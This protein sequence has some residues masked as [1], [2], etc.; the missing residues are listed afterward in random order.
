MDYAKGVMTFSLTL[1]GS[2]KTFA[3]LLLEDDEKN[4]AV[5]IELRDYLDNIGSKEKPLKK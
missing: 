4:W 2:E 3:T 1:P 5:A